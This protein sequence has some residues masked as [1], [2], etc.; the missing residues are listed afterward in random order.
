MHA[1]FRT[2]RG[3]QVS[4]SGEDDYYFQMTFDDLPIWGF[5]AG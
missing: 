4:S 2:Q 5:I 3:G 1:W